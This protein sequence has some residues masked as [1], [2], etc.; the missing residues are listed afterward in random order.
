MQLDFAEASLSHRR[1]LKS[2]VYG[3]SPSLFKLRRVE[4][5]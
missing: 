1:S 3:N 4:G 5:T 2:E